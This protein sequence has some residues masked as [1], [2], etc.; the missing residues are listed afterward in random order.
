M[1][2]PYGNQDCRCYCN[3]FCNVLYYQQCLPKNIENIEK[4]YKN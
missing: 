4:R 2:C 3:G 1:Y